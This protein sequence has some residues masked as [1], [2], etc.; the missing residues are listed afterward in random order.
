MPW[1]CG[2]SWL[3]HCP[4][5]QKVTGSILGQGTCLGCKFNPRSWHVQEAT[6]QY[7]S[8][9]SVFLSYS[10]P[11]PLSK[12]QN[13]YWH[14]GEKCHKCSLNFELCYLQDTSFLRACG[15]RKIAEQQKRGHSL[16][17]PGLCT[18]AELRR[19]STDVSFQSE[20]QTSYIFLEHQFYSRN[21]FSTNRFYYRIQY[22]CL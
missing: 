10:S 22:K 11:S 13:Y 16:C 5:H 20:R 17:L 14:L 3:E 18:A 7:F 4:I 21:M 12:K 15:A 6:D 9:K 2:S 1:L 8:F 19:C